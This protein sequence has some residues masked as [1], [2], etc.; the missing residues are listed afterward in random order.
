MQPKVLADLLSF[1]EAGGGAEVIEPV[2]LDLVLRTVLQNLR[3]AVK[4]SGAVVTHSP[5][6]TVLGRNAHFVQLLQNLIGN[7]IKY[8]GTSPPRVQ[9]SAGQRNGEWLIAVADNG[10]GIAP[11]YHE[12]VF[13][14]FKRL[15]GKEI[16]GT[17]IGLAI[18]QRVVERAGGRIWV[19]SEVEQG[20]KFC[21]TLPLRAQDHPTQ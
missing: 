19:E 17:G 4:E 9:L 12:Q 3:E 11:E 21:F 1:T 18:C 15:H 16:P 10:Q 7:A 5:L 14:V 20:S 2:N 13:G 8:R 6:P